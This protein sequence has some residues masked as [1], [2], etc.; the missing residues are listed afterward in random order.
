MATQWID[1]CCNLSH[2]DFHQRE[3]HIIERALAAG[4]VNIIAP[5]S[6]V[7]DSY[8]TIALA[9][10]H[11]EVYATAGVHPHLARRWDEH[12][13]TAL[14]NLVQHKKL[15]A[16]GETGLDY[17]RNYS[18]AEQQIIAF[19]QQIQLAIDSKLPLLMHQRDAHDDFIRLLR[20]RRTQLQA[21][22]V[23]CFTG[24]RRELFDYLDLDLHIGI[25]G[26]FC[27]ERRGSHLHVLIKD[28]PKDKLMLETDAPYLRPRHLKKA[29]R[30]E[31][32]NEPALLPHIA[33]EVATCLQLPLEQLAQ[34]TT[35]TAQNFYG[36]EPL[37]A[38]GL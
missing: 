35:A 38:D 4:V 17:C 22:V 16:I 31:V 23:H 30:G 26:W 36:L 11:Q 14:K 20:A 32:S 8:K 6:C 12:S 7:A 19:E 9:D 25:T 37:A 18:P 21:A 34:E 5:A 10:E 15:V 24:Q 29:R 33:E 27:D 1:T 3:R 2:P 13:Y 28:I